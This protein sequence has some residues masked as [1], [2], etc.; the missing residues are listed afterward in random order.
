MFSSEDISDFPINSHSININNTECSLKFEQLKYPDFIWIYGIIIYLI[1]TKDYSN[2]SVGPINMQN[3]KNLLNPDSLAISASK[4]LT[5]LSLKNS[6]SDSD[7]FLNSI[8]N[9]FENTNLSNS[10]NDKLL[11]SFKQF[12]T[13]VEDKFNSMALQINTIQSNVEMLNSKFDTLLNTLHENN[14]L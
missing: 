13:R 9:K 4:L 14:I 5:T 11:N 10:D 2:K 3:V 6:K 12:E 7:N 1:E 8:L